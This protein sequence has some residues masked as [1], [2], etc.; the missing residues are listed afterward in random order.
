LSFD[1][2][3]S[4]RRI[5][6]EKIK[7]TPTPRRASDR[8]FVTERT[9]PGRELLLDTTVYVDV[10]QGRAPAEVKALLR[11][12]LIN[13]SSVSV[14]ELSYLFGRLDPADARTPPVLHTISRV[15]DDMPAHRTRPP[16]VRAAAEA[17][18]MAGVVARL[19]GAAAKQERSTLN[20][21]L[22]YAH[23]IEHGFVVLT[24]NVRD[25]DLFDQLWPADG[26]LFY[27]AA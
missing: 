2:A 20:D 17:G 14:S 13:H 27:G 16:S 25:F 15:I 10:L 1:L 22:L 26:V 11:L 5:K 7:R 12:R 23:A 3:R 19:R 24:R 18:M 21:A 6:P 4:L 9:G 8:P